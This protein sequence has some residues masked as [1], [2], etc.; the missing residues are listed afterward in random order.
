[1]KKKNNNLN[2]YYSL[3]NGLNDTM[4]NNLSKYNRKRVL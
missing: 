3:N 1:M 4:N 2:N